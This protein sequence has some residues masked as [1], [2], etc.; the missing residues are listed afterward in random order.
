MQALERDDIC[1]TIIDINYCPVGVFKA[2]KHAASAV[3]IIIY[4]YKNK[5][6][7]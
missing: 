3:A 4:I 1:I 7:Q 5:L 6:H 2:S